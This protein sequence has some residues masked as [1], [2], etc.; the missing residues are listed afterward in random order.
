MSQHFFTLERVIAANREGAGLLLTHGEVS[1]VMRLIGHGRKSMTDAAANLDRLQSI[2][3][4]VVHEGDR[5]LDPMDGE[6][7]TVAR[8]EGTTVHMQDGGCM[9]IDEC[10]EVRVAGEAIDRQDRSEAQA[11]L[12]RVWAE[13]SRQARQGGAR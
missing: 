1:A 10:N 13:R 5:V 12:D 7:R 6:W 3:E 11:A 8:I 2:R 4:Y 9:D